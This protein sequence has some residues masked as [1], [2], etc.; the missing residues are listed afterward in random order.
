MNKE[1]KTNTFDPNGVGKLNGNLFGLPFT[2]EESEVIVIPVPWE[3]TVSYSS[4]TADGPRAILDASPQL[5]LYDPELPN[6]WKYGIS[7]LPI[8]NK[9]KS[10]SDELRLLSEKHI[11]NLEN[12]NE[13]NSETINTINLESEKLKNWIFEEAKKW[14]NKG[15]KICLVGGDH[16]TPLGLIEFMGSQYSDFGILQIDAHAD[17]RDSYEE[18]QY[19][20]ASIMFNALKITQLSKLV[21]VGIRDYCESEFE[22]MDKHPKIETFYDKTLKEEQFRGITWDE[23][24]ERIVS[25]LPN[26]VYIS[27]DIDG[28]DAKYCPNTG[29]PVPG[30][31]EFENALY[32]IKK[33]I[34]S[35]RNIIS[36][37]LN[38]VAPGSDEWNANVGARLLY[39]IS[40]LMVKSNLI[41]N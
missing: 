37:D 26:N 17:L 18:F 39:R 40:N 22:M 7:M 24:C 35:G 11:K 12:G 28:L 41:L 20:H 31:L 13:K 27:F 16:S 33:T 9:I 30:G 38:E 8:S 3:V 36:F 14:F 34:D 10:K 19:S 23:Q 25:K 1:E 2:L 4:G 5:D 29:T 21:Q 15:K 32:L 6:A